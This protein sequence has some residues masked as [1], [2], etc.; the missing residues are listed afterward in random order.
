MAKRKEIE[1]ERMKEQ[2]SAESSSDESSSEDVR[3][4]EQ[5]LQPKLI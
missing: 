1:D 3:N 2:E 5:Y 4:I